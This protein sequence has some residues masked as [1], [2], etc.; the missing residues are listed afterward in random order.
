MRDASRQDARTRRATNLRLH[1]IA[2]AL[3]N[4]LVA[5][6]AVF[7]LLPRP[8]RRVDIALVC[9][10]LVFAGATPV[11]ASALEYLVVGLHRFH[12]GY[13]RLSPCYPRTAII[14]PA[15]NEAAVIGNTIDQLLRLDYPADRLRVYV[16]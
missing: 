10:A 3:L 14:V 4:V 12:S 11:L 13:G 16:V 7:A 9:I 2:Y 8:Q 5:Q 15:W 6:A 1:V